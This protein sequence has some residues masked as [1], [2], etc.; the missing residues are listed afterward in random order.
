MLITKRCIRCGK[1]AK[2]WTGHIL[3]GKKTV[4]AGWCTNRC[5]NAYRGCYGKYEES[6]GKRRDD[7]K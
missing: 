1:E 2:M 3:D 7:V 5:L 6:M 4:I